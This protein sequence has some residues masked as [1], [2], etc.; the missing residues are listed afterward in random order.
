VDKIKILEILNDYN[1][2]NRS[3]KDNHSRPQYESKI[4]SLSK[5]NEVVVVKGLR[6]SGKSTLLLNHIK[7]LCNDIDI[8]NILFINLEDPRFIGHLNTE[9][10]EQI[11]ETYLQYINPSQKPYIFLDEIQNIPNFEKW[12]NKEYELNL[13]HLF[14]TGSNSSMLSSEIA[15]TLSGRYVSTTIYPLSFKEF[16]S[17]KKSSI[18]TMLDFIDKKI[19]VFR[20][21]DEYLKYGAFPKV[22]QVDAQ[23]KQ[24]LLISYKDSIL[25]KDIVA[26][27]I[28]NNYNHCLSNL[29]FLLDR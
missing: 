25:L 4:E 24:E 21:F 28:L 9:L 23:N 18:N 26:R 1:Y 6:R 20:Y 3:F 14:I 17:F 11:K 19:A 10:L 27:Y 2:W 5:I 8:K 12:I 22:V 7:N 15:S 29:L 16:L 13:S